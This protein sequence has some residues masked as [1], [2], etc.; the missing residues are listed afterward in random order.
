MDHSRSAGAAC[1]SGPCGRWEPR[2]RTTWSRGSDDGRSLRVG[3][4]GQGGPSVVAVP[5]ALRAVQSGSSTTAGLPGRPPRRRSRGRRRRSEQREG[6]LVHPVSADEVADRASG[7]RERRRGLRP[8][9]LAAAESWDTRVPRPSRGAASRVRRTASRCPRYAGDDERRDLGQRPDRDQRVPAASYQWTPSGTPVTPRVL[10]YTSSG[11][12]HPPSPRRGRGVG[13][14]ALHG[15]YEPAP[16]N[17]TRPSCAASSGCG[18]AVSPPGRV[19]GTPGSGRSRGN[20]RAGAS[21]VGLH[22]RRQGLG[23]VGDEVVADPRV[24]GGG[25]PVAI[26]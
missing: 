21:R 20:G 24:V 2:R 17:S 3:A 9:L 15:P 13:P 26:R 18:G 8:A 1:G 25:V 6:E 5:R 14:V 4:D 16:R 23:V 7:N 11:N 10:A 22:R 12:G 19:A